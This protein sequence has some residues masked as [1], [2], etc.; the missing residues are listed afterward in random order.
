M[1]SHV[2]VTG[3][4]GY[5]GSHTCKQLAAAGYIPIVYD[6][7]RRG[8]RWA[9]R[10]GPL[11]EAP[12]E[13]YDA[14]VTS[15]REYKVSAV[16]HFAAYAY[17]GESMTD[18]SRYFRN[19]VAVTLNVLDAMVKLHIEPLIISSSCAVYGIPPSLPMKESMP[20]APISPYGAS[21]VM[22]EEIARWYGECHG[23]R[24]V[25]LRYFNAAGTDPGGEIGEL[26]NPEP[27]LI[28]IVVEAALERR[29][30]VRSMG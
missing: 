17:V 20:I 14:L 1:K 10:W 16:L 19:N 7:L 28:P 24:T 27:H 11:I 23:L 13:D 29:N 30:L 15:M 18:P 22:L 6:D 3:G 21:K 2:L 4:A 5:V 26:H 25:A 12:L 9:V 8:N